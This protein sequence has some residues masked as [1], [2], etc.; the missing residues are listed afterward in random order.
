[1]RVF[2]LARMRIT[3]YTLLIVPL[4]SLYKLHIHRSNTKLLGQ[5]SWN[6]IEFCLVK[7]Y[8]LIESSLIGLFCSSLS[9]KEKKR[10]F[11]KTIITSY[12]FALFLA[13]FYHSFFLNRTNSRVDTWIIE[14]KHFTFS[15]KNHENPFF[16][17]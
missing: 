13:K 2:V 8:H 14:R 6:C 11:K 16:W 3:L 12:I 17:G 4:Y 5:F 15:L 9:K 1:M 7:T 10:K